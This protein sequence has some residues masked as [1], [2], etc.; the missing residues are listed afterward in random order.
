MMKAFSKEMCGENT[1]TCM[2]VKCS[3]V[4]LIP[5]HINV[6]VLS[7]AAVAT[8]LFFERVLLVMFHPMIKQAFV[9]SI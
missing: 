2:C 4:V 3:A 6:R 8:S 9:A 5:R 7:V 1:H